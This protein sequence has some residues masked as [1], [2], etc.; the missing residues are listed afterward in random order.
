MIFEILFIFK[1]RKISINDNTILVIQLSGIGDA[2]LTLPLLEKLSINNKIIILTKSINFN[3]YLNQPYITKIIEYND[4]NFQ[5]IKDFIFFFNLHNINLL[6][7]IRSNFKFLFFALVNNLKVIPNPIF[8]RIRIL[9][10]FLSFFSNSYKKNFYKKNHTV[11][12]FNFY[13]NINYKFNQLV[14]IHKEIIP[15]VLSDFILNEKNIIIIHFAGQDQIRKL[16]PEVV[17]DIIFNIKNKI[18]LL[19]VD[20]DFNIIKNFNLPKNVFNAIGMLNLNQISYLFDKV[21]N[22]ICVDSSIMHLASINNKMNMI[23]LIGNTLSSYYGPYRVNNSENI[24]LLD[25]KPLCSPC[26]KISCNKFNGYSCV[27]DIK[28]KEIITNTKIFYQE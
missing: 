22:I 4:S 19:G 17:F 23:C 20:N 13:F 16:K 12:I 1:N 11:N 25:R 6:L 26:S 10:R 15:K 8:E 3:I 5:N 2:I 14:P 24:I 7:S 27:Q 9:S 18:I 28:S 21:N